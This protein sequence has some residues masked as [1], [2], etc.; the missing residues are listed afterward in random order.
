MLGHLRAE[1]AFT[2]AIMAD[3]QPLQEELYK[4]MRGRIQE[5]DQSVPVRCVWEGVGVRGGEGRGVQR[6]K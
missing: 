4:E 6:C 1:N 5:A 2:Q 3:T